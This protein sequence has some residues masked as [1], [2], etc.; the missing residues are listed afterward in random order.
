MDKINLALYFTN[1][2][3]FK[4]YLSDAIN[5]IPNQNEFIAFIKKLII[6]LYELS[7]DY[8]KSGYL[9]CIYNSFYDE[10]TY[11]LGKTINLKKRINSYSTGYLD[12]CVVKYE[13][14]ILNNY[15]LAE[16]LL[17]HLLDKYRIKQNR[18]FF[19]CELSVI[20][21]NINIVSNMFYNKKN[22]IYLD[23]FISII[24]IDI[25]NII[26]DLKINNFIQL[27]IDNVMY[28]LK[29]NNFNNILIDDNIQNDFCLTTHSL[30]SLNEINN[31]YMKYKLKIFGLH[32]NN[33]HIL[34]NFPKLKNELINLTSGDNMHYFTDDIKFNQLMNYKMYKLGTFNNV[35]HDNDIYQVYSK[36]DIY[37]M[38]LLDGVRVKLGLNKFEEPFNT[39]NSKNYNEH[40][41]V[42]NKDEILK[43]FGYRG[44]P[45]NNRV[46]WSKFYIKYLKGLFIDVVKSNTKRR[47]KVTISGEAGLLSK[48]E[49]IYFSMMQFDNEKINIFN[50]IIYFKKKLHLLRNTASL[51]KPKQDK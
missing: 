31:D 40:I 44:K 9:Y 32:D 7:F 33:N 29:I 47:K 4:K 11:K 42:E 49:I 18:E 51:I 50:R 27:D 35:N 41:N 48:G 17:F 8:G 1:Q 10:N 28:N 2:D 21:D 39:I 19:K 13:S 25:S 30:T 22:I 14:E 3:N 15:T 34:Y 5:D 46:E 37:K 36:T 16:N 38:K 6:S 24:Q 26:Y 23:K 45:F 20:I 43:I 12:K